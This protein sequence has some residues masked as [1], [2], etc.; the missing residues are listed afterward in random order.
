MSTNK[1]KANRENP[2]IIVIGSG[3]TGLQAVV[4]LRQAGLDNIIVLEKDKRLGGTW[5]ENSYPGIACDVPSHT[6]SFSFAPNPS[7]TRMNSSGAE[8]LEYFEQV[9]DTFDIN[10]VIHFNEAVT[11]AS[12]DGETWQVKTSHDKTYIAEMV[13]CATGMLHQPKYP[14]IKNLDKFKGDAFHTARW[15]H[16][17]DL[18]GKRV[19]IIGTGS[20]AAQVIP[21]L[22]KEVGHL[23]V[24]QRTAQWCLPSIDFAYSKRN[25]QLN[26]KYPWRVKFAGKLYNFIMAHTISKSLIGFRFQKLMLDYFAKRHL[27]KSVKDPDLKA[28][29]TPDYD[30]GCKR[31]VLSSD[32]YPALQAPNCSVVTEG[33]SDMKEKGVVTEDGKLHEVD[34]LVYST[35]FDNFAYMRPMDLYGISGRHVNEIWKDNTFDCYKSVCMSEFP[36]FFVMLGPYSPIGTFSIIGL[37]ETQTDYVIKL[38]KKWQQGEMACIAPKASAEKAFVNRVAKGMDNTIWTTG[39][40]SWYINSNGDPV[41][42]PWTLSQWNKEMKEP[43]LNDFEL[44][45]LTV[46]DWRSCNEAPAQTTEPAV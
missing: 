25:I 13:L 44:G 3:M 9:A 31:M 34:V 17:I 12:F 11:Q 32:L 22:V 45:P 46:Q 41:V 39:C 10:S 27:N 29:L 19:G 37:S 24:F 6:Y 42:W 1:T 36:N 35:G 18:K 26:R 16:D 15:R 7:W 20:T 40:N 8:I 2:R 43:D 23:S 28:K 21:K 14:K 4:K 5:R 33:I 30:P 38:I